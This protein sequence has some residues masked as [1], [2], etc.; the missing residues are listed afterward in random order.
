MAANTPF[1]DFPQLANLHSSDGF[2]PR[3]LTYRGRRL[4][5]TW[6][7]LTLS[8]GSIVLV[9]IT[10]AIV[11]NLIPLYA[12]G[13]FLGFT[14][15]QTGMA[16]RFWRAG[17]L[18]PGEFT[19]GLET[20]ITYDPRWLLKLLISSLG[21]SVTFVVMIVF[22]ITKFTSGAWFIV[23]LIPSLV[24]VFFRIHRHYKETA[25]RLHLDKTPVFEHQPVVFSPE[26][27]NQLAIYF[28][29]T[30]SRLA[31]AVVDSIL[32][33]GLPVKII[34]IGVDEK[35][36]L[37]FEKRCNEIVELNG[38]PEGVTEIIEDPYRD[39][40]N[41]VASILRDLRHRYPDV[42]FEIYIGALRTRFPFS[43]LHMSTDKFLR[44]A[45]ME[46]DDVALNIKQ[47]DVDKL[48]LPP[49]F[50]VTF[51]HVANHAEIEQAQ[52]N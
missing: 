14:I 25:A 36:S 32:K 2:L 38:W 26:I 4:V 34:H 23:L 49:G 15:S 1:N 12:I 3:Q 52:G 28:C 17:R 27:H 18:K 13:V 47:I 46:A 43:L 16:R 31:V 44:D 24:W 21:A 42:Y 48:P 37:A 39:L 5:F 33:R 11:T 19:Y 29:D 51:E 7:V 22:I 8:F 45:L 9:I 50:K 10:G 40:Y 35:R 20:K 6:G 30:W 41:S